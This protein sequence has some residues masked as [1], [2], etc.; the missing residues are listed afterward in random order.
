M[1]QLERSEGQLEGSQG[2][3]RGTNGRT[4]GRKISPFY[5]TLSPTGA[6][7]QKEGMSWVGAGRELGLQGRSLEGAEQSYGRGRSW[8]WEGS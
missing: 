3:L 2:Q 4:N 5:R 6:A 1:A 8:S 7:A